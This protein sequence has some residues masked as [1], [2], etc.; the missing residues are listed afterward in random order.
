MLPAIGDSNSQYDAWDNFSRAITPNM[1][2]SPHLDYKPTEQEMLQS[3]IS[4]SLDADPA[5]RVPEDMTARELFAQMSRMSLQS[6]VPSVTQ[7]SDAELNDSFYYTVFPNM[8]PWGA[9]NKI[10]YRF[11]P[12][13]NDPSCCIMEVIYLVPFAGKRPPPAKV[14]WLDFDESWTE[15]PE[16][17]PLCQVF[18]QDT[19]NLPKVQRGLESAGHTHVTFASYQETK[20]RH[21]HSLLDK[22]VSA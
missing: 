4:T 18:D 22:Y 16:L 9:Y 1:T 19:I 8:H 10:T 17:G 12:Y 14:H 6:V 15:A 13:G 20:I 21:F 11:R 7:L 2:P 3:M 5:F